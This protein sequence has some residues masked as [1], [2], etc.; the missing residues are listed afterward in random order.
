MINLSSL[1]N[2]VYV[3]GV[4][5]EYSKPWCTQKDAYTIGFL[6]LAKENW[7][8]HMTLGKRKITDE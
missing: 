2:N 5:P 3:L 6:V 4:S 1:L 8:E 7:N